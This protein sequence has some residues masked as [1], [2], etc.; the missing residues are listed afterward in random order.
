MSQDTQEIV[1]EYGHNGQVTSITNNPRATTRRNTQTTATST[2]TTSNFFRDT[3]RTSTQNV[4]HDVRARNQ[5][6]LHTQQQDVPLINLTSDTPPPHSFTVN[7]VSDADFEAQVRRTEAQQNPFADTPSPTEQLADTTI[8]GNDLL[9]QEINNIKRVLELRNIYNETF[10]P[11]IAISLQEPWFTRYYASFIEDSLIFTKNYFSSIAYNIKCS[12]T[13]TFW[14]RHSAGRSS[15][16][17]QECVAHLFED[18][19]QELEEVG[20]SR[21]WLLVCIT[22]LCGITG[23][24]FTQDVYKG[25]VI[26]DK[27]DSFDAFFI[28]VKQLVMLSFIATEMIRPAEHDIKIQLMSVL[29]LVPHSAIILRYLVHSISVTIRT[30]AVRALSNVNFNPEHT[31][32]ALFRASMDPDCRVRREFCKNVCEFMVDLDRSFFDVEDCEAEVNVQLTVMGNRVW[33]EEEEKRKRMEE[34][35]R[36]LWVHDQYVDVGQEAHTALV[37]LALI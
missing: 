33:F 32:N 21:A 12:P 22:T 18:Y 20:M 10:R 11:L 14:E 19:P 30:G 4:S 23:E 36:D 13:P 28:N 17:V 2:T 31:F 37:T 26:D 6:L 25:I 8:T 9:K 16:S 1:I 29:E 34:R 24:E 27:L 7:E 5:R 3:T 15:M 35:L